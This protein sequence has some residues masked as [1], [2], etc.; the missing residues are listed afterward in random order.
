VSK[1]TCYTIYGLLVDPGEKT[2]VDL[3]E[4]IGQ[5]RNDGR[6]GYFRA[7]AYDNDMTFLALRWREVKLGDYVM[8]PGDR[9]HA[10]EEDRRVWNDR[11]RRAAERLGLR[12]LDGP[13]WFTIP[14]E[15]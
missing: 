2:F 9:P 14:D 3:D 13:G 1:Q 7:G 10:S 15:Y 5:V 12:V 8:H 11:L 4:E 6:V